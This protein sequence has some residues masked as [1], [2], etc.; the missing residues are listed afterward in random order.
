ME[1]VKNTGFQVENIMAQLVTEFTKC[2]DRNFLHD[3]EAS[4]ANMVRE[5]S[6]ND[7]VCVLYV[8]VMHCLKFFTTFT[9][10]TRLV[11]KSV[12]ND[13]MIC[14][15]T[16]R[17]TGHLIIEASHFCISVY[18]S[19]CRREFGSRFCYWATFYGVEGLVSLFFVP[20]HQKEIFSSWFRNVIP[21]NSSV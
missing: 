21:V 20:V 2:S 15:G 12:H 9:V 19:S 6:C 14:S 7:N 8:I 3:G 11:A 18:L 17:I 10:F 1:V 5:Y 13:V 4:Q 16:L